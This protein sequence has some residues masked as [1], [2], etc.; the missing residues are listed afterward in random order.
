MLP[1]SVSAE[2]NMTRD[3][4]LELR[5]ARFAVDDNNEPIHDIISVATTVDAVADTV[6]ERNSIAAEDWVFDGVDQWKTSTGGVFYPAKLKIP[7][8]SSIPRMS[9]LDFFLLFY[10]CNYIKLVLFPRR[11][12]TFP[13]GI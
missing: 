4:L 2:G 8:S 10:P 1:L 3:D 11:I 5:N 9:I 12:S 7:Y 6:I 13:T